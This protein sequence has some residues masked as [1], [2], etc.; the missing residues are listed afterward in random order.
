[1]FNLQNIFGDVLET[2]QQK[3]RRLLAE[4]LAQ[5]PQL[6]SGLF[7]AFNPAAQ[8]ISLNLSQGGRELANIGGGMLGLDMRSDSEKMSD[9]LLSGDLYSPSGQSQIINSLREIDPVRANLA[10]QAFRLQNL[11]MQDAAALDN[12]STGQ[13]NA[14]RGMISTLSEDKDFRQIME[15]QGV[16]FSW[17]G[18]LSDSNE[19][20]AQLVNMLQQM[21]AN[22]LD[23]LPLRDR[24]IMFALASNEKTANVPVSEYR[25]V[26]SQA[27]GSTNSLTPSQIVNR[28]SSPDYLGSE[29]ALDDVKRVARSFGLIDEGDPSQEASANA[30]LLS[31]SNI[32]NVANDQDASLLN[33]FTASSGAVITPAGERQSIE[34]GPLRAEQELLRRNALLGNMIDPEMGEE[35][36]KELVSSGDPSLALPSAS[37][38]IGTELSIQDLTNLPRINQ[39]SVIAEK[40]AAA[41]RDYIAQRNRS[42][43]VEEMGNI[44]EG[45]GQNL[46]EDLI[47]SGGGLIT[48]DT[49]RNRQEIINRLADQFPDGAALN[50]YLET[51]IPDAVDRLGAEATRADVFR[52]VLADILPF[53]RDGSD[54]DA[55]ERRS[56]EMLSNVLRRE[57]EQ[58]ASN[59]ELPTSISP[60]LRQLSEIDQPGL[61]QTTVDIDEVSDGISRNERILLQP[62]L[63]FIY[64]AE[65]LR[66]NAYEDGK[67]PDGSVRY[68]VGYGTPSKKGEQITESEAKRR[69]AGRASKDRKK[70]NAINKKYNFNWNENQLAALTS[71]A[72]NVGSIDKLVFNKDEEGKILYDSPRTNKVIANRMRQF[73]KSGGKVNR[74]LTARRLAERTLFNSEVKYEAGD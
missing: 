42:A 39:Q 54:N 22:G 51:A 57:S 7:Q 37:S 56:N 8:A 1:M 41:A 64:K 71:F 13:I 50:R 44:T 19:T 5:S 74:G 72:Y 4:D 58:A 40:D 24:V 15:D 31:S 11:Q 47:Q 43:R 46:V 67:N 20:D 9:S 70:I 36:I 10:E 27:I 73:D 62:T 35:Q 25:N 14:I 2:K 52:E 45:Y 26:F 16:E 65:G 3:K 49:A 21:Q 66:L 29:Q 38:S 60:D 30:A 12:P 23:S 55:V 6:G 61:P 63:D 68:S 33:P 48:E 28:N 34:R 69:A 32:K 53:G 17:L 18:G 59:N